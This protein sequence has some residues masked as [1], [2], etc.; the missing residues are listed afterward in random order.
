MA[1]NQGKFIESPWSTSTTLQRVGPRVCLKHGV[2]QQGDPPPALPSFHSFQNKS[3][4]DAT[5][6]SSRLTTTTCFFW[7]CFTV[8]VFCCAVDYSHD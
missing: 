5:T 6:E 1:D 3:S 7:S 4:A 8:I 2:Q